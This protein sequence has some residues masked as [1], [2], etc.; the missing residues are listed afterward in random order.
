MADDQRIA[1]LAKQIGS[2][3][4][5]EQ[6]LLLTDAQVDELRRQGAAELYTICAEVAASV[7]R[8]L[9]PPVLELAPSEYTPEMFRE[10]GAN[11]FQLNAQGRIVQLS[12]QSTPEKFS[13]QKFLTPYILEGEV[14]AYNQEMLER[15]Q[16]RS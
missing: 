13:T 11:V 4:K 9:N 14:H 6:H 16:V 10:S 2:E 1:R 8:L 12:F 7:N 3:I 15:T 5:K